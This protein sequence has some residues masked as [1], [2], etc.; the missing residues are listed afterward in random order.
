MDFAVFDIALPRQRTGY[1]PA[2]GLADISPYVT[3]I[4]AYMTFTGLEFERR[5]Q[6]L[7][8]ID[9]DAPHGKLPYII[10]SDGTKVADSNVI[11]SIN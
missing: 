6:D 1:V 9:E 2:W 8:R 10:D 7:A 5:T 3:K 4:I 11:I